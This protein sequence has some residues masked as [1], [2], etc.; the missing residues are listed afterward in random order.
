MGEKNESKSMVKIDHF[1]PEVGIVSLGSPFS[2]QA[3]RGSLKQICYMQTYL[4]FSPLHS[5]WL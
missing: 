4:S 5:I 2:P 1:K 3:D